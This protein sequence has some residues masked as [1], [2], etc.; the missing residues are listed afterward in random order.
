MGWRKLEE[1]RLLRGIKT[2]GIFQLRRLEHK[3]LILPRVK[4]TKHKNISTQ[5]NVTVT[6]R[7]SIPEAKLTFYHISIVDPSLYHPIH[8]VTHFQASSFFHRIID[9]KKGG[10]LVYFLLRRITQAVAERSKSPS[11][12]TKKK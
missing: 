8:G 10:R 4:A 2:K 11:L 5:E 6:S 9:P 7:R 3:L 1:Y 12:G